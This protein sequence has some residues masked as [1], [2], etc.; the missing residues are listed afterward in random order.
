MNRKILWTILA[1]LTIIVIAGCSEKIRTDAV[2]MCEDCIGEDGLRIERC[3]CSENLSQ[4]EKQEEIKE[5]MR[6]KAEEER[7]G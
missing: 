1:I 3:L 5:F 6:F 4:I 2:E 7:R